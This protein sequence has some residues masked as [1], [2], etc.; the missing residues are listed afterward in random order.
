MIISTLVS[1]LACQVHISYVGM[2]CKTSASRKV[3]PE[4]QSTWSCASSGDGDRTG[5]GAS[6]AQKL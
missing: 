2:S 6:R 4:L 3:P 5:G 1:Y